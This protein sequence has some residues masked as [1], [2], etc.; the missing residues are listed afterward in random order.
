MKRMILIAML[1]VAAVSFGAWS[2]SELN[3][4]QTLAAN[5]YVGEIG[6]STATIYAFFTI[7]GPEFTINASTWDCW[8]LTDFLPGDW[9]IQTAPFSIENTGGV[10]LDLGFSSARSGAAVTPVDANYAAAWAGTVNTYKLWN[11]MVSGATAGATM[12]AV[13]DLVSDNCMNTTGTVQWY[14]DANYLEP[15]AATPYPHATGTSL[16][17]YAADVTGTT[18][19]DEVLCYL[20][21]QIPFAGWTE[22]TRHVVTVTV[23]G[24]ISTH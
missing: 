16:N 9:G 22:F 13:A 23:Y 11:V 5:D 7:L 17:F 2:G 14:G 20:A 1:F 12:P 3:I 8:E 4:A 15:I 18:N 24:A 10:T 6:T 19:D 21:A